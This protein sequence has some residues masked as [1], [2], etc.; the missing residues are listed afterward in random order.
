M[1]YMITSSLWA[2]FIFSLILYT[3]KRS[4]NITIKTV[5]SY[6]FLL[7]P[8]FFTAHTS[9]ITPYWFGIEYEDAFEYIYSAQLIAS[10]SI[11]RNMGLNTVCLVGNIDSCVQHGSLSHPIGFS[12]VLSY[13]VS[14]FGFKLFYGSLVSVL[15]VMLSAYLIYIILERSEL[16]QPI[17]FLAISLYLSS[18]GTIVFSNTSL[19]EPV[20]GFLIIATIWVV[21]EISESTRKALYFYLGR[22]TLLTSAIVLASMVKRESLV[23][24]PALILYSMFFSFFYTHREDRI[25]VLTTIIASTLFSFLIISVFFFDVLLDFE[26]VNSTSEA[27]FS[28]HYVFSWG[29]DY[30]KVLFSS[31]YFML[32][33]PALLGA[34]FVFKSPLASIAAIFFCGYS[35]L[36]VSF[37]Q[38]YYS[39]IHAEVPTFHFERYAIQIL[40]VI[41]LVAAI[42]LEKISLLHRTLDFYSKYF[43]FILMSIVVTMV[44]FSIV[45][46]LK[47]RENYGNDEYFVRIEPVINACREISS[48]DTVIAQE[49]ILFELF[50]ESRPTYISLDSIGTMIHSSFLLNSTNGSYFLWLDTDSLDSNRLR[51]REAYS[52]IDNYYSNIRLSDIGGF[53]LVKLD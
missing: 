53:Q 37:S 50:C 41:A 31:K 23:I 11:A 12:I 5:P 25:A 4:Q 7:V 9:L 40:P 2:Y 10:D 43:Y 38:S 14:L 30:V 35:L 26:S 22:G 33:I 8:I 15:S 51:F 44:I 24:I 48:D 28:I 19:A 34:C 36:F 29:L 45:T 39:V 6:F 21:L 3:S 18:A 52:A 32:S 46:G 47:Q 42:G 49:I 27:V 20:S 17:R 13:F 1:T 16:N